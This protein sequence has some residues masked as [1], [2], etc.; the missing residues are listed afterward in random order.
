[1]LIADV[2]HQGYRYARAYGYIVE[3]YQ[4]LLLIFIAVDDLNPIWEETACLLVTPELIKADENL[5]VQVS[6]LLA[7][8]KLA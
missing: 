3:R 4:E 5:A 2:R 6:V 7:A 8:L 1:M